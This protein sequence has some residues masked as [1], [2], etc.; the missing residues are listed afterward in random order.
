MHLGSDVQGL[1]FHIIDASSPGDIVSKRSA[2]IS[3][4]PKSGFHG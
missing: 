3:S 4:T 2:F 1:V